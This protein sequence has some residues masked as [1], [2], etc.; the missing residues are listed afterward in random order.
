MAWLEHHLQL[1]ANRFESVAFVL[2][3]PH[4]LLWFGSVGLLAMELLAVWAVI[5]LP[6]LILL[7]ILLLRLLLIL[8]LIFLPPLI[9]STSQFGPMCFLRRITVRI[10]SKC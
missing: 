1:V 3:V 9:T 4:A 10:H 8:L 2:L 5:L 7:L 6:L